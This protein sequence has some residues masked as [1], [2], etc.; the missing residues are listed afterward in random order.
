MKKFHLKTIIIV[1]C[2]VMVTAVLSGCGGAPLEKPERLADV[3]TYDI[4]GN[5]E[6]ELNEDVITVSGETD[7]MDGALLHISVHDQAGNELDSVNI[8]KNGDKVSQKFQVTQNKYDD[9]ILYVIGYITCAP[10]YYGDQ[11]ESVFANYGEE[12]EYVNAPE[13]NL[14]WSNDG[15]MVLFNSDMVEF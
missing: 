4:T 3:P 8:I 5:C 11:T 9:S 2:L 10:T 1:L 13:G 15:N 12:F 7:F 6:L 14:I